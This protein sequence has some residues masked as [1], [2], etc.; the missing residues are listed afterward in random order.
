MKGW[1]YRLELSTVSG[2]PG[3]WVFWQMIDR[4][5]SLF[6]LGT[7]PCWYRLGEWHFTSGVRSYD[8]VHRRSHYNSVMFS[9]LFGYLYFRSGTLF[10]TETPYYDYDL[11]SLMYT[12]ISR[13]LRNGVSNR[14]GEELSEQGTR[15]VW[16]SDM[17]LPLNLSVSLYQ[18]MDFWRSFHFHL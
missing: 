8:H 12:R 16:S 4:E 15:K 10:N 9:W 3:F 1:Y 13:I 14:G 6:P 11:P 5:M 17:G 2:I 18:L 7:E